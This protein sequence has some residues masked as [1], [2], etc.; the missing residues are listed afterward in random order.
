LA[1]RALFT[2]FFGAEECRRLTTRF[3]WALVSGRRLT[4]ALRGQ[5]A[6]ADA[7]VTTWDSPAF[8][9]TLLETAPR[10]RMIAHCGGE[11]KSR[12]A[13]KLFRRLTITN[14]ADPMARHVAELA[15]AFLLY[16][17]RN[18]D[19]YRAELRHGSSAIYKARHL[20]GTTGESL[21]DGTVGLIGFGRIGRALVE[22]LTPFGVRFVVFDPYARRAVP[23]GAH[24]EFATLDE[25]LAASRLLVLAAALNDETRNL[26]DRRRLERLPEGTSVINVARGAI[27]DLDA[28][29][30]Q[31][32][33]GRLRCALDVTDPVDPLPEDHPLRQAP[34]AVLTPHVGAGAEVVRRQMAGSV[35]D[36]LER[37]FDGRRPRNRV[38]PAMLARMT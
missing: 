7:L 11:V 15:A 36:E 35:I 37:H 13:P 33:A 16:E 2:S 20:R 19:R 6:R 28:L 31:V 18:I 25:V 23:R 9:E 5:L 27:V 29:T 17:A 32:L 21:L 24:V 14:A 30:E 26:L 8:D 4:P 12:F 3:R 34:G 10:L 22:L 38:T 1:G